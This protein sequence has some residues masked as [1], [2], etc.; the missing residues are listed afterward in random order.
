MHLTFSKLADLYGKIF[1][2]SI[3]GQDIVV[4]NDITMLRNV[5]QG[6]EFISVFSDRPVIFSS[7][8]I[9]FILIS[10]L[11][12]TLKEHLYFAKCNI[13]VSKCLVKVSLYLNIK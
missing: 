1:K 3:L 9:F 7:K 11:E 8:H 5:L 10:L 12:E 2:V 4:I 6:E 13:K